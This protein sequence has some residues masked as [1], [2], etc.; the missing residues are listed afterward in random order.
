MPCLGIGNVQE[1]K[2]VENSEKMM[3][4]LETLMNVVRANISPTNQ[5][6]ISI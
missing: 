5:N 1:V 2:Q 6:E 4:E 3:I